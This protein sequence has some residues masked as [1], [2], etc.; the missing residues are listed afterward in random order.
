MSAGV[1]QAAK[2]RN[3]AL[4]K[5]FN[6]TIDDAASAA[7]RA[8]SAVNDAASRVKSEASELGRKA[9]ELGR[10]AA[11]AIDARRD[12]AARGLTSAADAIGAGAAK[13]PGQASKVARQAADTLDAGAQYVRNTPVRDVFSDLRSYAKA[14]PTQALVGAALV[15]FLAGRLGRRA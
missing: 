1:D 6:D 5:N 15:G 8:A 11:D 10:S 14:H 9:S 13:L 3:R 12:A 4:T 7:D 2:Q